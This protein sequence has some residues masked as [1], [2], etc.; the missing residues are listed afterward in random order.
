MDEVIQNPRLVKL[1]GI[2]PCASTSRGGTCGSV[3]GVATASSS[4]AGS[5]VVVATAAA[6][7]ATAKGLQSSASCR[8]DVA[9]AR[10]PPWVWNSDM[11]ALW[12]R[13]WQPDWDGRAAPVAADSKE[14]VRPK[15]P[16]GRIRH[17]LFIRHGQYDL[18]S[19]EQGLTQLGREQ[20]HA[21]GKRLAE[22]LGSRLK[23][24]DN[25]FT[26]EI[27]GIWS[28]DV[29]RARQTAEIVAEH[30][31]DV[32]LQPPDHIL[33]EGQPA[34]PSPHRDKERGEL[35]GRL[36]EDSAR[37]ELAFRRYVHRDVDLKDAARKAKKRAKAEQSGQQPA[38]EG[39][40]QTAEK[41]AKP[42]HVY[43]IVVCH[44]NVIRYFV[45]RAL[46]LPPEA[47]LRLGG[48]NTGITEISIRPTGS[49]TLVRFGD[50]GHLPVEMTT[51]H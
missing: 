32:P 41:P 4:V 11:C 8:D 18:Q 39:D 28:S 10:K 16:Q 31:P 3:V 15:T 44:C 36:W 13:E 48:Y 49:V 29:L 12:S 38:L 22:M 27:S 50:T 51:F 17:L 40:A 19:E 34:L 24:K 26:I 30:L 14:V 25:D 1:C 42:E 20:S 2:M 5:I 21:V 45:M 23:D 33:A 7:A 6:I 46:Q 9:E 35:T 47:W 37:I 43:E